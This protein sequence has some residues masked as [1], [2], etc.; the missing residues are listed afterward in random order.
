MSSQ[1]ILVFIQYYRLNKNFLDFKRFCYNV[2]TDFKDFNKHNDHGFADAGI[3]NFN[4]YFNDE[5]KLYYALEKWR[6]SLL[7]D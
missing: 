5:D 6:M 1:D 3:R 7:N 4:K 2:D